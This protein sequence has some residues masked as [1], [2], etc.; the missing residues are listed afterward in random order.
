MKVGGWAER[1][2]MRQ[3]LIWLGHIVAIGLIFTGIAAGYS[4][5]IPLGI[6]SELSLWAYAILFFPELGRPMRKPRPKHTRDGMIN[7]QGLKET[8]RNKNSNGVG[9]RQRPAHPK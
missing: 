1:Q 2:L 5:L 9:P 7:L 8:R 4:F 3:P 6:I